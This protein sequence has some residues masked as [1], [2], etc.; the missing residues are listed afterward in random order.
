[1]PLVAD[2]RIGSPRRLIGRIVMASV[3]AVS[4][5]GCS[6]LDLQPRWAKARLRMD[7]VTIR[8]VQGPQERRLKSISRSRQQKQQQLPVT[9][10]LAAQFQELQAAENLYDQGQYAQAEQAYRILRDQ[11]TPRKGFRRGLFN[12][13]QFQDELD[14]SPI[15][16][17]AIFGIAQCQ[18]MQGRLADAEET[19]SA[20]LKEY[21]ATRHLDDVSRQLFRISREWLGFPD[22]NDEEIVR[23][24]YGERPPTIEQRRN[25]KYGWKFGDKTRPNFDVDG[26][27]LDALRLIWLHDAAGPLADDALMM[28]AN[29][30]LR[31]GD[32]ISAAQHYRLLQEQFPNSPHFKDSLMLGSH[33]L[34]AS[35]NG[36]GYDPSP[37]EEA[38]QLKLMALQYPDLTA[39]DRARI[40]EELDQLAE[41]EVEP[42]WKQVEFYLAK[43]QPE[44]VVLHC[45]MIINRFP[46]SRYAR[47]AAE[48]RARYVGNQ[49]LATGW[50]YIPASEPVA[51]DD[52]PDPL[53]KA[54]VGAQDMTRP[55]NAPPQEPRRFVPR[56]LRRSDTPPNLQ[57]VS[58]DPASPQFDASGADPL[59]NGETGK[60]RL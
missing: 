14:Q 15:E 31:N 45:N 18:F 47:M 8:D 17:D 54:Y 41:A 3:C 12:R 29:Y 30:H 39:D 49:K 36:A 23:V 51:Q 35:Y 34:L 19:Y 57:P 53:P 43:R 28:A 46:N 33:V 58:P 22:P 37:L 52:K 38:K 21:P 59:A 55:A 9:A 6:S 1:M 48:V 24:A 32:T 4:A 25:R 26:H 20:L 27:A 11:A 13:H 5:A 60:T 2:T 10:D 7:D 56:M 44:S 42:L 50:P 40:E 16:E